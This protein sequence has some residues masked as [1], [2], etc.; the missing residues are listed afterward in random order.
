MTKKL[1]GVILSVADTI[2]N[3]GQIDKEV[4]YEVAKLMTF[5]KLRGIT[6]V[7]LANQD[8]TITINGER[9]N[10]YD[11]LEPDSYTQIAV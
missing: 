6:P 7:L 4:F 9:S 5:F 3:M 1:K 11:Y 8:R 2:L 10:L